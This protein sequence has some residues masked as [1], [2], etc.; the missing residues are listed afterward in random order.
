[1]NVFLRKKI[2]QVKILNFAA[3]KSDCSPNVRPPVKSWV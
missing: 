2:E 1:M 3:V